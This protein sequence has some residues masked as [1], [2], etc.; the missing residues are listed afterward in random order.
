[1]VEWECPINPREASGPDPEAIHSEDPND[2]LRMV[3]ETIE[4]RIND[5]WATTDPIFPSE[6]EFKQ[7]YGADYLVDT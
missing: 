2:V 6:Y 5:I 4:K 7:E 1:M 3:L